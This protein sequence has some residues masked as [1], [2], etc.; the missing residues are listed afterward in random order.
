MYIQFLNQCNLHI[1][2]LVFF[3][4]FSSF[5]TQTYRIL[6][7]LFFVYNF[8]YLT[9]I[10]DLYNFNAFLLNNC[11][12]VSEYL[13]CT[14]FSM[15]FVVWSESLQFKWKEWIVLSFTVVW[16]FFT[17]SRSFRGETWIREIIIAI[18]K[19]C[20]WYY[21]IIISNALTFKYS[22]KAKQYICKSRKVVLARFVWGT[23]THILYV[24]K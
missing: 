5:F 19:V 23:E 22:I 6:D 1:I 8:M 3:S 11:T 7:I 14:D 13:N 17:Y 15:F 18:C 12:V 10:K 4:R 9:M 24:N 2:N 16:L 21:L 20:V